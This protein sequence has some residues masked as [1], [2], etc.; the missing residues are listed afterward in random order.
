[1]FSF[2]AFFSLQSERAN[3]AVWE[4]TLFLLMG[5]LGGLIG[6]L[7]NS[8]VTKIKKWRSRYVNILETKFFDTCTI[9]SLVTLVAL[10]APLLWGKCTPLPSDISGWS[11]Q[12]KALVTQ[13]SPLYCN[14]KDEYNELAS[15]FLVDSDTV[16]RQLLHFR[17]VGD[18]KDYLTFSSPALLIF[19]C[20]YIAT[21][22]VAYGIS[23]PAGMF[24][25][26]LI[27]G[28]A[29]G[30]L[31]GHLL[32]EVDNTRGTFADSG[33]Y[34]LIGAVAVTGGIARMVS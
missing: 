28:A 1:M 14:S 25:P 2:G 26:S 20:L 16:I 34:A 9:V 4:L 12:E 7:F 18:N 5:G 29:F 15:L 13:L 19:F 31:V 30:R 32:H 10:L 21:A 17:E 11:T 22:C 33:T 6:A 3:Y 8:I 23:V 27:S 24:V